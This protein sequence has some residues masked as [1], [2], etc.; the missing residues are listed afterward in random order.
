[1]HFTYNYYVFNVKNLKVHL[2]S[3]AIIKCACTIFTWLNVTATISHVKLDAA[4]NQGRPLFKGGVYY[5]EAPSVRL[6]INNYNSI[7][8]KNK[9]SVAAVA[10]AAYLLEGLA[11]NSLCSDTDVS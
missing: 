5:T 2:I 10:A 4:T 8:L 1:M 6:L 7:E 11:H 3:S 9:F